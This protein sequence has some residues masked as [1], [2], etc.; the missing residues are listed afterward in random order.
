MN[1]YS[2][3]TIHFKTSACLRGG[4]VK[5][6][7]NLPTDSTRKLP[8]VGGRGQKFVK[9]CRH[10]KWMVPYVQVQFKLPV[11][12]PIQMLLELES[13]LL[14]QIIYELEFGLSRMYVDQTTP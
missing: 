14:D 13:N 11:Q 1:V 9:I 2:L 7:P 4:G 3:G 8:M 12:I 6:L 5:N 10:L